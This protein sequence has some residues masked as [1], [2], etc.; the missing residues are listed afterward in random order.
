M[1][2]LRHKYLAIAIV[3]VVF[4][5][6]AFIVNL[7]PQKTERREFQNYSI[8]RTQYALRAFAINRW[9]IDFNGTV[10]ADVTLGP[11]RNYNGDVVLAQII[12]TNFNRATSGS[13][14]PVGWKEKV[15]NL[16]G[17]FRSEDDQRLAC[18]MFYNA[19]LYPESTLGEYVKNYRTNLKSIGLVPY[20]FDQIAMSE[21]NRN[22]ISYPRGSQVSPLIRC[23]ATAV[24]ILAR[25]GY[26][27]PYKT[28]MVWEYVEDAGLVIPRISFNIL[29]N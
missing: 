28:S 20:S 25:G 3:F 17:E 24:F 13:D 8:E 21:Y 14:N 1:N 9:N 27:P 7:I 5:S 18:Q 2:L 4:I 11:F 26:S 23:T 6:T 10:A 29:E 15:A 19:V 22:S 12:A 16:F